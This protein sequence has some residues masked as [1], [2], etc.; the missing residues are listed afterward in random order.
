MKKCTRSISS[1]GKQHLC[2]TI[3]VEP[4]EGGASQCT[5]IK[6]KTVNV[7]H[8][9]HRVT[10]SH[11]QRPPLKAA[12]QPCRLSEQG[13]SERSIYA[14]AEARQQLAHIDKDRRSRRRS[15]PAA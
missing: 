3:D 15:K 9:F 1:S 6:V 7:D 10:C 4:F 11:K 5:V 2:E 14:I 8:R 12:V 13:G